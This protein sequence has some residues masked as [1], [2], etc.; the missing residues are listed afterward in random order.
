MI[1]ESLEAS[2]LQRKKVVTA[3]AK[4]FWNE[5]RLRMTIP[6]TIRELIDGLNDKNIKCSVVLEVCTDKEAFLERAKKYSKAE[7]IPLYFGIVKE[8]DLDSDTDKDGGDED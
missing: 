5:G 2:Y 6:K 1:M 3:K 4:L 8:S 7:I